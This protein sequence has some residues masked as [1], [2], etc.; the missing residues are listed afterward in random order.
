MFRFITLFALI[1]SPALA[2]SY[3]SDGFGIVPAEALSDERAAWAGLRDGDKADVIPAGAPASILLFIGPKALV[4]GKDDGHAVALAF[5]ARGN[6]VQDEELQ[7]SLESNGTLSSTVADGIADALFLPAPLAGTFAGGASIGPLQSPRALYR[8]TTDLESVAPEFEGALSIR[9]EMFAK[10][11]S[12]ALADQYGNA[13][14][15]GVGASILLAHETGETTFLFAPV[16]EA[17]AE[18]TIL[19]RGLAT[20]GLAELNLATSNASGAFDYLAAE[21]MTS[22]DLQVWDVAEI[23]ALGLRFGPVTTAAG[24]LLTDGAPVE[25]TLAG[26]GGS[27]V[28]TQGWLQ[29]GYFETLVQRPS[30]GSTLTA[31]FTT[32]LGSET[33]D[34]QIN[35]TAPRDVLGAE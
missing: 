12:N 34:I 15:D 32:P 3:V 6:L 2:E 9:A 19:G 29:D 24:H 10:L 31:S 28:K 21:A 27:I 16:R 22:P 13:V 30:F 20:G 25:V 11:S 1:G 18:A 26:D 35:E 4:A 5:D 33:R 23:S 7:F 14:E 8:V 17:K